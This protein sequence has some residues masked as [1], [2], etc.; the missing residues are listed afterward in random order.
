MSIVFWNCR[1]VASKQF[2]LACKSL[3]R[4]KKPVFIALVEPRVSRGRADKVIKE[5]G[6]KFSR[7]V[8]ARGFIGRIW[9]CWK[10]DAWDVQVLKRNE[11]FF[12]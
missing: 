4:T 2:A 11:N 1:G 7:R 6:F 9:L 12:M 8:D 5:L 3:L 10:E